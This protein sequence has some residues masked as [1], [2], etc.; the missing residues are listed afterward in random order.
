MVLSKKFTV[1]CIVTVTAV[2]F[3]LKVGPFFLKLI[4]AQTDTLHTV[5]SAPP[6]MK[7]IPASALIA[8]PTPE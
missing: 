8:T 6:D 4:A 7:D 5:S 1:Y 2:L 3:G